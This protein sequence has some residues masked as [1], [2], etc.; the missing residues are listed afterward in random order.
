M[1]GKNTNEKAG[2]CLAFQL[3]LFS[4]YDF[5]AHDSK[6]LIFCPPL[7]YVDWTDISVEVGGRVGDYCGETLT[8]DC[9][10][11]LQVSESRNTFTK[12]SC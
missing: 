12:R 4:T 10:S 8:V 6:Y 7:S 2:I 3:Y 5:M 11:A 1:Q 9:G